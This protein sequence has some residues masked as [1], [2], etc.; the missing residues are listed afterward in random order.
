MEN[1]HHIFFIFDG[2]VSYVS[3]FTLSLTVLCTEMF[4]RDKNI[5]KLLEGKLNV[6][7]IIL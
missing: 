1:L 4:K 6:L 5:C 2:E 3:Y 7:N